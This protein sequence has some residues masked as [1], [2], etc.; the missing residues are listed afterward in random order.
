VIP[1]LL[2]R[3]MRRAFA[4]FASPRDEAYE[5]AGRML[6]HLLAVKGCVVEAA[7]VTALASEMVDLVEHSNTDVVCISAMPPMAAAHA[8]YLCKRLQ[9]RFPDAYLIVGCGTP[10]AT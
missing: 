9:G 3:P 8:R 10:Q 6:A 2:F 1:T 4:F 5:I 7:S